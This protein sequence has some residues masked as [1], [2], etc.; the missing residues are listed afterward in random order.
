MLWTLD[1][2]Y[3]DTEYNRWQSRV[4]YLYISRHFLQM[5]GL[6]INEELSYEGSKVLN[7]RQNKG[8]KAT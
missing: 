7:S 2:D 6:K 5:K 3:V 8:K 4:D 1:Q